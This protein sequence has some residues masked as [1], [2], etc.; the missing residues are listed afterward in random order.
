MTRFKKCVCLEGPKG[1]SMNLK[2]FTYSFED[3]CLFL[4]CTAIKS[5]LMFVSVEKSVDFVSITLFDKK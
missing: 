5:E 4:M 1:C 2:L 3:D